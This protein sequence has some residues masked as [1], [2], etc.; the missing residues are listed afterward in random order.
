[1]DQNRNVVKKRKSPR[2]LLATPETNG[3]HRRRVAHSLAV[4]R[5]RLYLHAAVGTFDSFHSVHDSSPEKAPEYPNFSAQSCCENR[6]DSTTAQL[7][8]VIK[9]RQQSFVYIFLSLP[10]HLA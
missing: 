7:L 9:Y 5:V 4:G 2:V 8:T 10:D 3:M 1:M 6:L